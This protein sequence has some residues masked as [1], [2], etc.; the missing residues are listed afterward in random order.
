MSQLLI[1]I[2]PL[3]LDCGYYLDSSTQTFMTYNV[4]GKHAV[5]WIGFFM[6]TIKAWNYIPSYWAECPNLLYYFVRKMRASI[7]FTNL[8]MH[9]SFCKA[10]FCCSV[11]YLWLCNPIDC[12]HHA[13]LPCPSP[14]LRV[15]SNSCPLSWWCHP[16][17]S[18]SVIPFSSCL[19]S[20]PASGSFLMSHF[21]PSGGQIIGP[22]ISASVPPVN[23][24]DYFLLGL[25][26]LISLLSK[27]LSRVYSNTTVWKHQFFGT[28]PSLRSS[29][30]ITT[31]QLENP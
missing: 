15:C 14:S 7:L 16:T 18:S 21:F 28:Q 4:R 8:K 29:S 23:I 9:F 27:G 3:G 6:D 19:Q 13:R 20:F 10:E 30:H 11:S 26:G 24:Q 22:A 12:M 5:I 2:F 31:W 1:C 25:I 17:I